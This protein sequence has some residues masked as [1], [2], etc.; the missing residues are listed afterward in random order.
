MILRDR[1][2]VNKLVVTSCHVGTEEG[3]L[4]AA[5]VNWFWINVQCKEKQTH[6]FAV[7]RRIAADTQRCFI[8]ITF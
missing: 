5:G 1:L 4:P 7:L 2:G 6:M 8:L 3:F